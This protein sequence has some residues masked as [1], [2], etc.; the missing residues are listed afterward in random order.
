MIDLRML[1]DGMYI[2][3]IFDEQG[4]Y[5]AASKAVKHSD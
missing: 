1:D 4:N 2:F 5:I 3:L